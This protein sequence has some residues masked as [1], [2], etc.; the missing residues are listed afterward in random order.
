MK[1]FDIE[2]WNRKAQ[3]EFFKTYEDP[4]F[5]IIANIEV[6]RLYTYCKQHKLSFLLACIYVALKALNEIT[7]FKLRFK[8]GEVYVFDEVYMGSTILNED[9]T[10]SFC[11]FQHQASIFE[12][13]KHGKK[14]IASHKKGA[15]LDSKEAIL[16]VVHCSTFPW[17]SFTGIKHARKGD[18]GS[19][20][21][22]K[23]VFGKL[24]NEGETKKIPFS[25]EAHHALVDGY[26]VALLFSKMQ[27]II[28]ELL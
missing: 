28:D 25:V 21:I 2:N 7:E 16:D 11:Y 12:F 26:H 20:G 14:L 15:I 22:P 10:F 6:S 5:N 9:T 3:Y 24:F 23:I 8:N 17:V 19:K 4:F 1:P 27:K 13:D 18:E